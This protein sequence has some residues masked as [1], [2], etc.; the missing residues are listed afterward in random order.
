MW[1]ATRLTHKDRMAWLV[2]GALLGGG[3]SSKLYRSLREEAGLAYSVYA[4]SLQFTQTGIFQV[5]LATDRKNFRKSL[6]LAFEICR[7]AKSEI[8]ISDLKFVKR[9]LIGG[10]LLS[11]E[12]VAS[13]MEQWGRHMILLSRPYGLPETLRDIRKVSLT[14]LRRLARGLQAKPCLYALGPVHNKELA[15]ALKLFQGKIRS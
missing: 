6:S 1:P 15:S 8:T 13:R 3:S 5:Y 12:G 10:T 11:L 9:M 7:R 14:Q 4:Q 2:L